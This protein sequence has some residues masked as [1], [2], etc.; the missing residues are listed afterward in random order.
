[1]YIKP[2]R[3]PETESG[4][5]GNRQ[6]ARE[7]SATI[8]WSTFSAS[9]TRE[10][11]R[12]TLSSTLLSSSVLIFSADSSTPIA[13][14]GGGAIF[15]FGLYFCFYRSLCMENRIRH[16]SPAGVIQWMNVR[17]YL[18]VG[19]ELQVKVAENW[20]IQFIASS[21]WEV[22]DAKKKKALIATRSLPPVC[23]CRACV[24]LVVGLGFEIKGLEFC[25][26]SSNF[27]FHPSF[28]SRDKI[29][30]FIYPIDIW[31]LS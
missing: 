15:I 11:A 30:F 22:R 1:M 19:T 13:M 7:W 28:L 4:L 18:K 27:V 2:V 21:L 10:M 5:R 24:G 31:I 20:K 8:T 16:L 17:G 26:A 23:H 9:S 29:Y 25:E 3:L 12:R 14:A 6:V